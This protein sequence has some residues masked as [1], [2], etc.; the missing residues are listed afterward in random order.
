M[1]EQ[2][3]IQRTLSELAAGQLEDAVLYNLSN[4]HGEALAALAS[5]WPSLPDERRQ[6][7]V[8]RLAEIAEA[9]FEA[10]FCELFKIALHDPDPHVRAAA[11]EGLWEVDDVILVRPMVD[12]LRHDPSILVREAAASALSRFALLAEL[13]RLPARLAQKVWDVLWEAVHDPEQDLSVRRRSIEALAYFDRPEVRRVIQDA[14]ADDEPKMRVSAVFAMGRSKDQDWSEI[15][16]AELETDDPE[17]R[18]EA[19]RACGELRLIEATAQLSRL[20]ADVDPEVRMVAVWSLGQIGT[21]EARRVLEICYE[22]GDE[23][24]QD[25][26]DDA[27]AEMDFIQGDL[28]FSMYDFEGEEDDELLPWDEDEAD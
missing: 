25:A 5:T 3:D 10:D 9:D 14:Y 16:L 15:V 8:A 4:L 21:P 26:A 13:G 20:V 22:Q 28:D 18:Y 11:I 27:L 24:L 23:A 12:L 7:I 17:M 6:R 2:D 19:A 1:P